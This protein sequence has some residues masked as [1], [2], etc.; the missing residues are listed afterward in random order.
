MVSQRTLA[1]YGWTSIEDYF[2]YIIE[3]K[4]NGQHK[5]VLGLIQA[6]SKSQKKHCLIWFDEQVRSHDVEY[7]KDVLIKE[8]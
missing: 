4:I 6:M 5:Q 2:E 3:S 1:I 7:C 8:L